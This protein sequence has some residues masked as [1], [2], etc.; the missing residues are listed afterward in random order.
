LDQPKFEVVKEAISKEFGGKYTPPNENLEKNIKDG[1]A[2]TGLE[3]TIQIHSDPFG[4]TITFESTIL[5]DT[6]S[7]EVTPEGRVAIEKAALVIEDA[8]EAE[9]IALKVVVEGHTDSRPVVGGSYPSNWELSGARAARV[10]RIFLEKDY[11]P[12]DLIAIG[13]ADTRPLEDPRQP[14]GSW[15]EEAL[16]KN[17]RVVIRVLRQTDDEFPG[18]ESDLALYT[19]GERRPASSPDPEKQAK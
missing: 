8:E 14:D 5:F 1:F 12:E 19:N 11:Y 16:S 17:R 15:N 10:V 13:F 18:K 7:A 9:D 3:K 2:K 6:L 4:V